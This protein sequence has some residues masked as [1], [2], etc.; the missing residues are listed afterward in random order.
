MFFS[1]DLI[2]A[3][4]QKY[5]VS[6]CYVTTAFLVYNTS[7]LGFTV[8]DCFF[9]QTCA[10]K[11]T[12][13]LQRTRIISN[14]RNILIDEQVLFCCNIRLSRDTVLSIKKQNKKKAVYRYL[15][16][17]T[18]SYFSHAQVF[19]YLKHTLFNCVLI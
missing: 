8:Y 5:S 9:P 4:C 3:G 7:G 11:K 17:C 13:T 15:V 19:M 12:T 18:T 16:L 10:K 14:T 1:N 2:F 6:R